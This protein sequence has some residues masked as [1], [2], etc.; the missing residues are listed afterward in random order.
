M[1]QL[2]KCREELENIINSWIRPFFKP[3]ISEVTYP[4][5][6]VWTSEPIYRPE[7]LEGTLVTYYW[8]FVYPED[9][10]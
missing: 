6:F 3:N 4:C 5:I 10:L 1:K 7:L 8:E 2:C 9:L